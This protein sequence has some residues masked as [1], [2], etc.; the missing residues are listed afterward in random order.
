MYLKST[1]SEYK[2]STNNLSLWNNRGIRYKLE[3]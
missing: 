1:H 2:M 3:K